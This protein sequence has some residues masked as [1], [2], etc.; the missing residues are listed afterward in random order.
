MLGELKA[1]I[2]DRQKVEKWLDHIKEF[3]KATR[4][5]VL[6]QCKNDAT[7]RNYYTGRYNQDCTN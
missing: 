1:S 5:E 4:D 2:G 7:A 6:N 3:D